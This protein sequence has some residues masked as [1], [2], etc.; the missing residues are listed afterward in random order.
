MA[1]VDQT[2]TVGAAPAVV[3]AFVTDPERAPVWQSSLLEARLDPEGAV[4]A[5]TQIHEVRKLLGR[6]IE[7]IVE[8]TELEPERVFAGRVKTGPIPWSFTYRFEEADASTRVVFHMEGEP[9]GFFRLAEP[10]VIRTVEKQLAND[11]S[12]LKELVEGGDGKS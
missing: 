8:V 3:F 6:R 10:L 2:F 1:T 12:T 11:F 7:S 9:G 4:R 5:G